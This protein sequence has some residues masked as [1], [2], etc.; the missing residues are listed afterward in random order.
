LYSTLD[1]HLIGTD[2]DLGMGEKGEDDNEDKDED[3]EDEDDDGDALQQQVK[4]TLA[5][6]TGL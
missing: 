4:E 2:F 3:D 5:D 6:N 1:L